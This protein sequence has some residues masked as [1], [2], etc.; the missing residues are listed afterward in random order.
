M[1]DKDTARRAL[2]VIAFN[3]VDIT[4]SIQRYL[5]SMTYTDN[6]E[7]QS[8]DLQIKLHDRDG[9]WLEKWLNDAIE[10]AAATPG[11]TSTA[12]TYKVT[13]DIGLN[14]RSG[15]GSSNSK[16]GAFAYGAVVQVESIDDGWAKIT[17]SG[18][19]A[20]VSAQYIEK[21]ASGNAAEMVQ[22]AN[23]SDFFIQAVI[24]RENWKGDGK[25]IVLDCGQFQLDAVTVSGPPSSIAIEGVALPFGAGVRQTKRNRAWESCLLSD[26]ADKMAKSGGMVCVY[27]SEKDPFYQRIEQTETEDIEF[28]SRLC[29]DAALSLKV[30]NNIIV[31][32]D[33][34]VFEAKPPV[35]EIER[36]SGSYSS[37]RL[38]TGQ[39]DRKY[40]SCRVRYTEPTTGRMIEAIAYTEGYKANGKDNL[41]LEVNAKVGSRAEA[42]SLAASRLKLKNKYRTISEFTVPGNPDLVAGVTVTLTKWGPWS[43]KRIISQASH[44]VGN[45]G[46][47]TSIK[48][49]HVDDPPPKSADP[50]K[51]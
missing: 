9:L 15:P 44:T 48:L 31:I 4:E 3:G 18:K 37:Y 26:V 34:S 22:S 39:A 43:G 11:P 8:D 42:E 14:I 13:A 21:V 19:K 46:Y 7:D 36:G 50:S 40:S 23:S 17:Y 35:L 33:P 24:L 29:H 16:L 6:E 30:T 28:L 12:D 1:S 49:R 47:T 2:P 51:K 41:Q 27:E 38:S 10:A 45:S 5:V 32:F 20:Y 25:D